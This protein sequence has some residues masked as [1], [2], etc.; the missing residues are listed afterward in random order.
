MD[1]TASLERRI[2][3]V[4]FADLVGFTAL[5]ES[6]DA[7]DVASVQDAYF[8]LVREVMGRYG[9]S[10][11][12]FIGDAAMAVFGVPRTN[13]DDALHAVRAGLA[14]TAGIEALSSRLAIDSS[15]LRLRVGVNTGEVAYATGGPDAGRVTGDVVNVA[16]RLQS[17]AEPGR[18]LAGDAT[19]LAIE[20]AVELDARQLYDL[21]GKAS[22][23]GARHIAAIRPDRS[24]D[25]A[26]GT[27]RAPM[28][29][30]QRES[31]ELLAALE[32]TR[33][34]VAVRYTVVA[35]P[36][37]GKSRL[38]EELAGRLDTAA[39]VVWR[40]RIDLGGLEPGALVA[41][42]L[43]TFADGRAEAGRAGV[44]TVEPVSQAP[45]LTDL[46]RL[47]EARAE[48]FEAWLDRFDASAGGR[49]QVWIV[50]DVHRASGDVLAFLARAG[51]RT[52]PH[53]RFVLATARPSLH[54]AA[55]GW[56]TEDAGVLIDLS[57]LAD[58]D[59]SDLVHALVGDA[60]PEDLVGA[61]VVRAG[62]NPL[63]VEELLRTWVGIGLLVQE[64]T[65]WR[66]A[67]GPS[68]ADLPTTVQAVYAAQLDDLPGTARDV[69]RRG[70]VA[71]RRFPVAALRRLGLAEGG[72][73]P[74]VE[75]LTQ[76]AVIGGPHDDAILGDTYTYRHALLRDAGYAS[77]ARV[78]RARLHVG[79]A[80]WLEEVAG[81]HG[82]AVA[83]MIGRQY[84]SAVD[85]LPTLATGVDHLGRDDLRRRA[86]GWLDRAALREFR[87]A[88]YDGAAALLD[89][90]I[91]LTPDADRVDRARRLALLGRGVAPSGDTNRAA[92]HL[93]AA[94]TLY[95][96]AAD[97]G[98]GE[99]ARD[100]YAR[101]SESLSR[102][103]LEQLRFRDG[104]ALAADALA[105]VG[106]RGDPA[107]AR[108][109]LA[110]AHG[111][112][113]EDNLPE[114]AFEAVDRVVAVARAAGDRE[115][116]LDALHLRSIVTAEHGGGRDTSWVALARDLER[117]PLVVGALINEARDR[118]DEGWATV[119]PLLEESDRLARAHG[120]RQSLAWIGYA[121]T[122]MHLLT[123]SWDDLLAVGDENL[124]LAD[125]YAYVR[126]GVRTWFAMRPV[127]RDRADID[128]ASRMAEWFA[129]RLSVPDSPYGRLM[130]A[131]IDVDLRALGI[132]TTPDPEPDRLTESWRLAYDDASFVAAQ[133]TVLDAWLRSD[134]LEAVRRSLAAITEARSGESEGLGPGIA[135]HLAG[136]P[137]RT[138]RRSRICGD[139]GARGTRQPPWL[140][141]RMVGQSGHR[142]PR[143][144]RR[145]LHGRAS[146]AH[147]DR[148]RL[149]DIAVGRHL[150]RR[151]STPLLP[152]V[153][154]TD[155]SAD[156]LLV[157]ASLLLV[158]LGGATGLLGARPISCLTA[159][160][161]RDLPVQLH[162]EHRVALGVVV[163]LG[164]GV[165]HDGLLVGLGAR[166]SLV[167]HGCRPLVRLPPHATTPWRRSLSYARHRA[168]HPRP[169]PARP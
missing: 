50:E 5:A 27:L 19:C 37:T 46:A 67:T 64:R 10:L 22:H 102:L 149:G 9:G 139:D 138:C 105:R 148:P 157:S 59:T 89:E 112:F 66:L 61:V 30:R 129:A 85:A 117:W 68:S 140:S 111:A 33:T 155:A 94:R 120:L 39:H 32:R 7:E 4:L 45:P 34:G 92:E 141:G 57:P 75:T 3:T 158:V 74:G 55:P 8:S 133:D 159:S 62:G 143:G 163:R 160:A 76:R 126:A 121:R 101:A 125:R 86:A 109:T 51:T 100:G 144:R 110:A 71:G 154:G 44:V 146:R 31:I 114:P 47:S 96:A 91:R 2:V 147:L 38:V 116:E 127:I 99:I 13:E 73:G 142:D 28:L 6:L 18:V 58:A 82:D 49:M 11:E 77:L 54:E 150:S 48:R 118:S 20:E 25:H 26:M 136:S 166:I 80:G 153:G 40:S 108:L 135:R 12:K 103:L 23:V 43:G 123:G 63:F 128:R 79:L 152:Q 16:A 161:G 84:A 1:A 21:R 14:L 119:E 87:H 52:T 164:G 131:A 93:E 130:H 15:P 36:G 165:S 35:P 97:E 134:R 72:I 65:G 168:G 151:R 69:A 113:F 107:S 167:V 24:R 29:G 88:A 104:A 56:P 145:S 83:E 132:G 169:T 124:M 156:R 115:L 137:G 70:A 122:E 106:D 78:D 60:L 95:A 90:A 41:E 81:D 42:L 98:A 53:G 17:A 162:L